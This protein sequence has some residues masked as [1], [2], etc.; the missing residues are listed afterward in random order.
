MEIKLLRKEY[1]FG[2]EEIKNIN[3]SMKMLIEK[4][5][6]FSLSYLFLERTI[7]MYLDNNNFFFDDRKIELRKTLKKWEIISIALDY[8]KSIDIGIYK[9]I[10]DIIF[11][12]NPKIRI[13]IYK[14][15]E[16]DNYK[17]RDF[18]FSTYK[19]YEESPLNHHMLNRDFIYMP[20][21]C[22]WRYNKRLS[23][24]LKKDEGT[25]QDL[26]TLVHELSH[27][28][29]MY[30]ETIYDEYQ[31]RRISKIKNENNLFT[32]STAIGFEN[33]LTEFLL[34]KGIINDKIFV[35]EN[36]INRGN[37]TINKCYI[38]YARL[39]LSRKKEENGV[40]TRNDIDE[41]IK[42]IGFNSEEK[43]RLVKKLMDREKNCDD[44]LVD[45][46]YAFSGVISPVI[47]KLIEQGKIENIK[48]YLEASRIGD[49]KQALESIGIELSDYGIDKLK[50]IMLENQEKIKIDES[51]RACYRD[52]II[53]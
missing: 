37:D 17:E 16:I 8:F 45:A 11:S 39:V 46:G 44:F 14:R 36:I 19:K 24:S 25:L 38:T 26:Y 47:K 7:G 23:K 33:G 2:N 30:L 18:E 5:K 41:I 15:S 31:H 34:K 10:R 22:G 50:Q 9:K 53:N 43:K 52:R 20:I 4:E 42:K 6:D 13:N 28:L 29:D 48:K 35:E 51:N 32:E 27:T 49:F 1:E 40:V 3:E 21:Q 12:R